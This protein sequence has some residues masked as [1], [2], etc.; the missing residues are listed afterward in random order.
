MNRRNRILNLSMTLMVGGNLSPVPAIAGA[1]TNPPSAQGQQTARKEISRER[2]IEIAR[3]RVDFKPKSIRA[4]KAIEDKR[5]VWRVTFRGEPISKV[6]VM[7]ETMIVSVD[8]FTG[9]IVSISK[10]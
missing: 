3:E 6:H 7:G 8:R 4:A 2:A 5:K 9:E 10:S 1:Q